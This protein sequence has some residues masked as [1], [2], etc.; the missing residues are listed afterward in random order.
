MYELVNFYSFR[1]FEETV[2]LCCVIFVYFFLFL[3]TICNCGVLIS[4]THN[5]G[6]KLSHWTNFCV[7][8]QNILGGGHRTHTWS[9]HTHSGYVEDSRYNGLMIDSN[10]LQ[11]T[12]KKKLRATKLT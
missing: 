7:V 10:S 3:S 6:I 9:M 11:E 2:N 12:L 1:C 8:G 4:T 5:K